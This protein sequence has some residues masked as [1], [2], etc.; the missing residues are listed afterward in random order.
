MLLY[1]KFQLSFP[2]RFQILILENYLLVCCNQVSHSCKFE[3]QHWSQFSTQLMS[4]ARFICQ[5]Q[6]WLIYHSYNGTAHK[7]IPSAPVERVLTDNRTA[8]LPFCF[9]N[10][11]NEV[12]LR[13]SIPLL[14]LRNL[15]TQISFLQRGQCL[16]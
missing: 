9:Q 15:L 3:V 7:Q 13:E 4:Q 12:G 2:P 5:F 10:W 1:F 16:P 14:N 11:A 8:N 6:K